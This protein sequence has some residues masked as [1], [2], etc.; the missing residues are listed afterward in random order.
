MLKCSVIIPTLNEA[1][2]IG[3]LVKSL[4]ANPYPHKEIIVVDA[5]SKDGTVDIAKKEGAI[6]IKERGERSP[7]NAR[8]LGASSSSGE[9]LCFLDGDTRRVNSNFISKAMRHFEDSNVIGVRASIKFPRRL[10]WIGKWDRNARS[11]ALTKFF[12]KRIIRAPSFVFIEKNVFTTLGGYPRLGFGEDRILA[13]EIKKYLDTHYQVKIIF[14]PSSILY[15]GT[16][17]SISEFFKQACWHGRTMIPYL[18][19]A[20]L[21]ITNKIVLLFLPIGYLFSILSI[22]LLI[23]FS[24]VSF[25]R[26]PLHNENYLFNL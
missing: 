23:F 4:V 7:A 22:S 5:G 25:A 11:S 21:S 24:L 16:L 9:V 1:S 26:P 10:P 15:H 14:E 19:K 12:D 2:T 6:V 8:N 18:N 13:T 3:G 17:C 20:E